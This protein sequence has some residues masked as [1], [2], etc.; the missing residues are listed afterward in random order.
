MDANHPARTW[1][2]VNSP[3]L[4]Q[5]GR[6]SR[7]RLEGEDVGSRSQEEEGPRPVCLPPGFRPPPRPPSPM[8]S[9]ETPTGQLCSVACVLPEDRGRLSPQASGFIAP[10]SECVSYYVGNHSLRLPCDGYCA[11]LTPSRRRVY[12]KG[13]GEAGASE[14]HLRKR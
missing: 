13:P 7:R 2:R 4:P 14:A 8:F 5:K 10:N 11:G 9:L 12:D 1:T 3:G 6:D